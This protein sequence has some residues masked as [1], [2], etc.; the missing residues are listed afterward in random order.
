MAKTHLSLSHIPTERNRPTGFT[1]SIRDIRAYTAAGMLVPLCGEM[2]QM[3]GFG[4]ELAAL[5]I[6]VDA[7]GNTVWLFCVGASPPSTHLG[8][9]SARLRV[10]APD[11]VVATC[12]NQTWVQEPSCG[13]CWWSRGT[14]RAGLAG[15]VVLHALAAA[16]SLVAPVLLGG[17]SSRSSTEP[18]GLTS[19]RSP[20]CLW[21]PW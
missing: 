14:K 3:P 18:P 17:S 15:V 13:V 7:D 11:A 9:W 12:S 1:V 16:A 20:C 21:G 2:L 10:G 19:T 6:D 8:I 5:A 4:A